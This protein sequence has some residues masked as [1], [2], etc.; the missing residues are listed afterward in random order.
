MSLS[1]GSTVVVG[2]KLWSFVSAGDR[3]DHGGMVV[4]CQVWWAELQVSKQWIF[5]EE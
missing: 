4:F 2:N 5:P 1:T 3:E